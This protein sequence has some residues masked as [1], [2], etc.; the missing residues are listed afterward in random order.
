MS[1][2]Q[3]LL[4]LL[5]LKNTIV[6]PG[7]TQVIKVGRDRS[8]KALEWAEKNGFWIVAVQQKK[9]SDAAQ[10]N[11]GDLFSIGTLCRIDSIRGNSESGYQVVLR[12]MSRTHLD[13]VRLR[14]DLG[15]LEAQTTILSDQRDLNEPTEK[16]LLES[17]KQLSVEILRLV[18]ANTEQLEELVR[19]VEDL[20]YLTFL[21]A[22]NLD[23]SS[24]EKQRILDTN[25]LRERTLLLLNLM[26]EF[27]EGL[28]IQNEIRMKMTQK[29]GQTQRQ[30]LLREQLKAIREELG[31]G[32]DQD[33]QDKL[34][35][36]LDEAGLPPEAKEIADQEWK[37]LSD[38]GPQ[39]PEYHM[40][41]NYLE[42]IAALPWAKSAPKKEIRL[43]EAEQ[44]LENDHY[45]LDKIK[46]RILQ[47]LAVL[48]LKK[49]TKGTLLLF[50]G[51]P[52]VGKTSLAQSIARALGRKFVR[53]SLGGVRDEAEIRGH[54]RTYI[55]SM[56]GRIIQALK[57]AGENNAVF[58]LDEVDKLS[59]SFHGDP[60]A[61]LLEVLDPEQNHT[62]VDHYL[63]VPFDLS[64]VIFL[65]TA[66]QLDG[67]PAPLLDR[68]EIVELSGYTTAEKLHIARKHLLPKQMQELGLENYRIQISDEA[69]LRVITHYTREAGVRDLQ[70]KIGAILRSVSERVV[71]GLEKDSQEII[72]VEAFALESMLGPE[73]FT[74]EIAETLN[75]PGVVT[76]LAWSPA[77][78]ELLFIESTA[79]PGKSDLLITGQ[80]GGVMKESA[81]IALSL[82]RSHLP[83]LGLQLDL[84]K[85]DIHLHVPAGAIPKDGPS[86]GCAILTSMVSL[87]TGR[88][89]SSKLAMTGEITLRG[90]VMPVGG[91][92]EKVIAAHRA[93]ITDIILPEKNRRDV[94]E[95]PPEVLQ[96]LK[97]HY[98]SRVEELLHLVLGLNLKS[99]E[100]QLL[101]ESR[102][103]N[104][105]PPASGVS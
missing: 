8:V 35:K 6:F 79:M 103:E 30:V 26:K 2:P 51:P 93:G 3:G 14:R 36:K 58:L 1:L 64:K 52:G 47:Q 5:A 90:A 67:I 40:L 39:S 91:I 72:R 100:T 77:G 55:G 45:G 73:R 97:I 65:A 20:S 99:W 9:D 92:K 84:K 62:F 82:I 69:I 57:K 89:V 16:A 43:E 88:S 31:E 86:A 25:Q 74:P 42:T 27:K 61:A 50:V 48:K 54:R 49:D 66:N 29:L 60:S 17:L 105:L 85:Y 28:E 15:F 104:M 63:D 96:A 10:V 78:G 95:I 94:K 80:L 53:V 4:P 22:G 23:I 37:R 81:Q 21:C 101:L 7:L 68:M 19:G 75:P 56:P 32:D 83:D 102:L 98:V 70:R 13:E 24:L 87:L 38:M 12:G 59:H 34:K 33:Q 11:P 41:R 76:G 44:I 18:P 71:R 46:K